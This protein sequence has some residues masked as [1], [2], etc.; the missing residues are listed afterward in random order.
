MSMKPRSKHGPKLELESEL[1]NGE[2]LTAHFGLDRFK[3]G[4]NGARTPSKLSKQEILT[5][6]LLPPALLGRFQE[7]N[8]AVGTHASDTAIATSGEA[9]W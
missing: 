8:H 7:R 6:A 1:P 4:P 2:D 3:P 5:R 9:H